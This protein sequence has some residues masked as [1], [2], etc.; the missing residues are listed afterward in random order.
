[1]KLITKINYKLRQKWNIKKEYIQLQK[2]DK[3][4]K[5]WVPSKKTEKEIDIKKKTLTKPLKVFIPQMVLTNIK[6][7]LNQNQK[8]GMKKQ[9]HTQQ[10]HN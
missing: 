9:D 4:E 7:H 3:K 10:K 8:E 2:A 1:M 5:E 6:V